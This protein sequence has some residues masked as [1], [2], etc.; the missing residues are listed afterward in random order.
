MQTCAR[1]PQRPHKK[2]E[3]GRPPTPAHGLQFIFVRQPRSLR[4][5]LRTWIQFLSQTLESIP[6]PTCL[7]SPCQHHNGPPMAAAQSGPKPPSATMKSP[8]ARRRRRSHRTRS[9]GPNLNGGSRNDSHPVAG[10]QTRPH[11]RRPRHPPCQRGTLIP[12]TAK[13]WTI[14]NYGSACWTS[15]GRSTATTARG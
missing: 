5:S 12:Q 10:A 11:T 8:R 1:K 9:H 4:T 2:K 6:F 13:T 14:R 3:S 15:R 7:I